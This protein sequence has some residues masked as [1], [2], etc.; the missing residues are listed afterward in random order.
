MRVLVE[1]IKAK[2]PDL[3]DNVRDLVTIDPNLKSGLA[4]VKSASSDETH[5]V[6]IEAH[7]DD[8]NKDNPDPA[9]EITILNSTC[10]CHAGKLC[11]HVT[12]FYAV[13]KGL[14][15]V[16]GSVSEKNQEPTEDDL[17][18]LTMEAIGANAAWFEEM[19]RRMRRD[20]ED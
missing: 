6:H 12:A 18:R 20:D 14:L 19:E 15:P 1:D 9:A 11:W 2:I 16:E 4:Y 13:S 5:I 8:P 3:P 17:R 10:P 7:K